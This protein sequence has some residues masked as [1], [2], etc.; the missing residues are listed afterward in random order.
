MALIQR[1]GGWV[2]SSVDWL[3]G[4]LIG[5]LIITHNMAFS[6]ATVVATITIQLFRA[7]H[8]EA[9]LVT[10]GYGFGQTHIDA[11]GHVV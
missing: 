4:L 7:S 1:N 5:T 11:R 2:G 10:W 3:V 6:E 8:R 9:T